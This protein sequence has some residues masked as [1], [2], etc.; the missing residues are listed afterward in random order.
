MEVIK[1][2]YFDL[3]LEDGIVRYRYHQGII[4]DMDMAE[5]LVYCRLKMTA[6]KTYPGF[7]DARE[8]VYAYNGAKKYLASD[9][10]FTGTSAVAILVKSHVQRVIANTFIRLKPAKIPVKLF[11][12]EEKALKWLEAYK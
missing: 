7:V 1:D 10:G 11:T 6:G 3:W 2:E 9:I 12:E 8:V 4:I 5:K